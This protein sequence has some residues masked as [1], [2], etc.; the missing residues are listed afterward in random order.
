MS[1]AASYT[2]DTPIYNVKMCLFP[3]L[4]KNKGR[5]ICMCIRLFK[6]NVRQCKQKRTC[7][8]GKSLYNGITELNLSA[9]IQAMGD[10]L[11]YESRR[12]SRMKVRKVLGGFA[13]AMLAAMLIL[14]NA[15]AANGNDLFDQTENSNVSAMIQ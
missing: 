13:W 3:L 14:V 2:A 9:Q 11:A 4:L 12:R 6:E 15:M 8:F 7:I 1:P 5:E 10:D